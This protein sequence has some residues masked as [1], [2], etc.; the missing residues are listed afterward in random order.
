VEAVKRKK[1]LRACR[2]DFCESWRT[3]ND[4]QF[5]ELR[6][7]DPA[8]WRK[9]AAQFQAQA[10]EWDLTATHSDGTVIPN[11]CAESA[12]YCLQI[13]EH[14]EELKRRPQ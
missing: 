13:A 4:A 6:N 14:C 11:V 7:T 10:D 9:M 1:L 8:F 3:K 12:R 5:P 2:C